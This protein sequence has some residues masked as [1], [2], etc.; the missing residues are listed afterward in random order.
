MQEVHHPMAGLH[1]RLLELMQAHYECRPLL[2]KLA[3]MVRP[4]AFSNAGHQ[5]LSREIKTNT[6]SAIMNM[7]AHSQVF[8]HTHINSCSDT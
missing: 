8:K 1:H 7:A 2:S 4:E 3:S 5:R 6:C